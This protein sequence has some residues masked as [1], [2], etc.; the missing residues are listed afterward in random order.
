MIFVAFGGGF[1]WGGAYLTWA[2]D[3]ATAARSEGAAAH[4]CQTP[5]S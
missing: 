4:A 5:K 1:A 3:G 2:Y